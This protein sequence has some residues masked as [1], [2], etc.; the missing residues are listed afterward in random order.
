MD[1]YLNLEGPNIFKV[2]LVKFVYSGSRSITNRVCFM[3]HVN[4]LFGA[5]VS[6]QEKQG[7]VRPNG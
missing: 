5:C 4:D 7:K 3:G 6:I 2:K 1:F